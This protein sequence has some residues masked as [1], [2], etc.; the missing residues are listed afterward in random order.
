MK[1]PRAEYQTQIAARRSLAFAAFLLVLPAG[2]SMAQSPYTSPYAVT[3]LNATY[4]SD[5]GNTTT[6]GMSNAVVTTTPTPGSWYDQSAFSPTASGTQAQGVEWGPQALL[7]AQPTLPVGVAGNAGATQAYYQ[8]RVIAA[9]YSLL[10][11]PYQHHHDPVWNPNPTNAGAGW[12]WNPV[13]TNQTSTVYQP[14]LVNGTYQIQA[15]SSFPNPYY[16]ASATNGPGIDCSDTT[17]LAY[18]VGAGIY[19]NSAVGQQGQV[20][21]GGTYSGPSP[22]GFNDSGTSAFISP[23]AST[24]PN[25]NPITPTFLTGPNTIYNNGTGT[26]GFNEPG[27]LNGIVSQFQPGDLLYIVDSSGPTANVSHVVMWLGQYGTLADGS[28]S[29]VPLVISSHDNTPAMLDASGN[30]P[31][32]GVE[33]LP[34]SEDSWFYTNFSHSMRLIAVP[35]P[36][37]AALL[38]LAAGTILLRACCGIRK[39]RRT[40]T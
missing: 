22:V 14:V 18:N 23:S 11:T 3:G 5:I 40:R 2:L 28:P 35:E 33:I 1:T 19:I 16:P 6:G 38:G 37:A 26:T 31:P 36:S 20:S 24:N 7:E 39:K 32:P 30:L 29:S 27:S 10:G 4:V 17:A 21:V 8:Q 12:P 13:S 25:I 34:F 9:A 15:T